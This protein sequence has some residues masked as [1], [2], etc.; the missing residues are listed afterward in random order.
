[1]ETTQTRRR[2]RLSLC[3]ALRPLQLLAPSD[4]PKLPGWQMEY[5][6][7]GATF[8]AF[9]RARNSTAADHEARCLLSQEHPDFNDQDARL[10]SAL[11]VQ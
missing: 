9:V 6:C 7:S 8:T 1:M 4:P 2:A 11:Q 3:C 10:V 5:I